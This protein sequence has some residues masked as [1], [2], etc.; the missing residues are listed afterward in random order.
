M[1]PLSKAVTAAGIAGVRTKERPFQLEVEDFFAP[2]DAVRRDFAA[3]IHAPDPQQ[4]A[5]LPAASYGLATV[6]R[7]LPVEAGQNM[8]VLHEQFPSNIYSWMRLA[9]ETGA[10]LRVIRPPETTMGRGAAWNEAVLRAIDP[11]T[12]LVTLPHVHWADGTVFDLAAIGREA[13]AVGAWF[14]VDGTQSVGALPFDVSVV[15]PDALICAAY[16]WLMGP[17]SIGVAYYGPRMAEGVP[18]EENWITRKGSEN[19]GGLV[20]YQEAYQPGAVRYDVG[21]RSNFILLPMLQAGLAHVHDWGPAHIQTYCRTLMQTTLDE[22]AEM[23]FWIENEA[24]RGAHLFGIRLPEGLAVETVKTA[25][26]AQQV[27][28]STRGNAL[29]VSPHVYNTPEDAL[30]LRDALHQCIL[31]HGSARV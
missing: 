26:A 4:I 23:G 2:A 25:L 21:E 10:E 17:Y 5:V 28:V 1:S 29:R 20:A 11:D 19:F 13:R 3:L 31:S 16:K 14:V 15:K 18:L 7:N 22:I 12:A 6:A 24:H 8:V 9:Q 30:A 27:Y